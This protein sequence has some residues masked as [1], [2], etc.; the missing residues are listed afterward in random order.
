MVLRA[1][2]DPPR[3]IRGWN[4]FALLSLILIC[5][6]ACAVDADETLPDAPPICA[7]PAPIRAE[8]EAVDAGTPATAST[9]D[10]GP[11]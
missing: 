2:R 4:L 1:R 9:F 10:R 5:L 11:R 3:R 7:C 8:L 6:S